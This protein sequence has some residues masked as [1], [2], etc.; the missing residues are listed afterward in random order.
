MTLN[1]P[2]VDRCDRCGEVLEHCTCGMALPAP[3]EVE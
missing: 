3:L 1:L 2:A